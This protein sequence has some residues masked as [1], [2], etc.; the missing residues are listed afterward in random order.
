MPNTKGPFTPSVCVRFKA[1]CIASYI[2]QMGI[3]PFL[4]MQ[5]AL[6]VGNFKRK[7]R[8]RE[9]QML[10]VNG[11]EA[12][13]ICSTYLFVKQIR[14]A[15]FPFCKTS[16]ICSTSLTTYLCSTYQQIYRISPTISTL[17]K[18]ST[19]IFFG[20]KI[21]NGFIQQRHVVT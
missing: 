4:V 14:F 7:H 18:I 20:P 13:S 10:G 12:N 2:A 1:S 8:T 15:L 5:L 19:L 11:P 6:N 9:R 21:L 3:E 16:S 17:S